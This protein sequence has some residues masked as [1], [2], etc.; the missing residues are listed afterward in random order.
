MKRSIK[1]VMKRW[2]AVVAVLSAMVALPAASALAL[3]CEVNP[4]KVSITMAY[5]GAKLTVTGNSA[6]NDDLIIKISSAPADAVMKYKAKVGGLFW[7]KKGSLEFKEVPSV[8]LLN[9]T[10][11]LARI[12]PEA[13][14]QE[15]HLGYDALASRAQ[16]V[17]HDDQP[18]DGKWFQEFINFKKK[19]MVYNVLEGT[20][21]RQHGENG[22]TYQVSIDWPF[23]ASPGMYT[24]EA[25]AVRDGQI[26]EKATTQL[27]VERAGLTASLSKMAFQQASLYGIMAIIIAMAAGFAVGAIFKKGGGSH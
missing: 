16:V 1:T 3:T 10:A 6:L 21:T 5:H 18:V 14:L 26:V 22:N 27:E 17:D 19:E 12:L 20:V 24:V 11:D 25:M 8:Y 9:T 13:V 4:N 2:M 23:Q 7:M 15:N